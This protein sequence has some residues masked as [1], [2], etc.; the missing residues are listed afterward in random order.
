MTVSDFDLIIVGG[1]PS[2]SAAAI[3]ARRVGLKT[4]ILDKATFPRDKICGDALSGKSVAILRELELLDKV[5]ELPGATI[6]RII[7]SSPEHTELE[8]NLHQSSLNQVPEGF[9]IRRQNFDRFM[10]EEARQNADTCM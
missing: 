3:Y 4:L 6:H 7:F 9:V 2:G 5:R 1:G 10:F 8:I